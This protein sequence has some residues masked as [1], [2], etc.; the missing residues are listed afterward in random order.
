MFT[1]C[2]QQLSS[3]SVT[4]MA[5]HIFSE[6][7]STAHRGKLERLILHPFCKAGILKGFRVRAF[8]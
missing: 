2:I 3:Y 4:V 7:C 8:A 5:R 1:F 6:E